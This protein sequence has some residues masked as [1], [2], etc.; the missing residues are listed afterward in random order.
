[1]SVKILTQALGFISLALAMSGCGGVGSLIKANTGTKKTTGTDLSAETLRMTETVTA[2]IEGSALNVFDALSA[3]E[4][5]LPAH[6]R[7]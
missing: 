1:M 5:D 7:P 2:N 3:S 4:E 6:S